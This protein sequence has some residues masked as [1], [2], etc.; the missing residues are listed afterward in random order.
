MLALVRMLDG[1]GNPFYNVKV[2]EWRA[3]QFVVA[4]V[5]TGARTVFFLGIRYIQTL[6]ICVYIRESSH[7]Y[8]L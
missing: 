6:F 2:T 8:T 5:I 3:F 4:T 7:P 1:R